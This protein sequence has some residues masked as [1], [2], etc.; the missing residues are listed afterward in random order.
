MQRALRRKQAGRR[1][2][3]SV[4]LTFRKIEPAEVTGNKRF[5]L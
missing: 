2:D 5:L 1:L 3:S 4:K